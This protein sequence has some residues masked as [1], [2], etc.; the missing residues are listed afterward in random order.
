[1][2]KIYV[3]L[4][5]LFAGFAA[6]AQNNVIARGAEVVKGR[7]IRVADPFGNIPN[8][9]D[10]KVRD[11]RGIIGKD[12]EVEN[13]EY[14]PAAKYPNLQNDRDA[15]VQS[16]QGDY[17]VAVTNGFSGLGYTQV[18][19]ADPTLAVGPNH[20]IQMI[21]GSSGAYF[22]I[23]DKN[24]G[25]LKART[26]M[27]AITGKGGLGD[28]V[29]LYDQLADRFVMTEFANKSE[30][31]SDGLV[32]AVSKTNDPTGLWNVYFYP[33]TLFPDY[34][35]YSV[36]GDAYYAKTNDFRSQRYN[37]ASVYAFDKTAMINGNATATMQR[38]ALGN[39][40]K[41]YTMCPVGLSGTTTAPAGTGG[42][43]AYLNDNSWSGSSSDSVGIL[44]FDVN[45]S[46]ASLSKITIAK[47]LAVSAYTLGSGTAPQPNGGQGLDVLRNRV[48]NQPQYRNFGSSASI[49][50]AHVAN[51]ASGIASVRWY[52]LTNNGATW[53]VNQQSTYSPDN[54]YRY[55]PSIN[56]NSAGD[57]GLSYNVSSSSVYPSIRFTGRKAGDA[58]NTMTVTEGT[59][60]AGTA[61]SSCSGRYGDYNHLVVDP[62]D[63]TTFWMTGMYNTASS[64]ST[65]INKF[66]LTTGVVGKNS[67]ITAISLPDQKNT[68]NATVFPNPASKYIYVN[69]EKVQP[70]STLSLIDITGKTVYQSSVV[71]GMNQINVEN[72]APGVYLL[73]VISADKSYIEKFIK[74]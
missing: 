49:V 31:G 1:M 67:P 73:K 59:L 10:V 38:I 5:L 28:P 43:F 50:L 66:N 18:C 17:S 42:L 64:W 56:I 24:G 2:K 11:E 54:T 65:Y 19:P 68:I 70:Q 47:S 14:S 37:G 30:A 6:M 45:F 36:W 7:L 34:P 41:Y 26:Y 4:V 12:G 23:W 16:K 20:V 27:D 48:M 32:F 60:A 29:V 22:Q 8:W 44:E 39:S 72:I 63:N 52:E 74:E 35:K 46:N 15:A 58:L 40:N 51:N 61:S 9:R 25:T 21:N 57:I 53:S 55:M 33:T 3:L 71:T 13:D 62:S 69:I